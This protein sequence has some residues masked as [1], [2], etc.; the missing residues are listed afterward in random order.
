MIQ[1]GKRGASPLSLNSS[2]TLSSEDHEL[3]TLHHK[4][5]HTEWRKRR[6][7]LIWYLISRT[8]FSE[9]HELYHEDIT[10]FII[11]GGRGAPRFSCASFSSTQMS[12]GMSGSFAPPYAILEGSWLHWLS[13]HAGTHTYRQKHMKYL[14]VHTCVTVKGNTVR[15]KCRHECGVAHLHASWRTWM[16]YGIHKQVM[17]GLYE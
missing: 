10:H 2:I 6:V 7:A 5:N 3:Y 11:Q 8:L 15:S 1:G 9:Y 12:P 13:L 4:L 16:R 17:R 14:H